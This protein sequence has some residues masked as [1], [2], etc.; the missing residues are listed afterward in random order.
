[1]LTTDLIGTSV[2]FDP[3]SMSTTNAFGRYRDMQLI[4]R[5][6][7]E[8]ANGGIRFVV[9]SVATGKLFDRDC[10]CFM[11]WDKSVLGT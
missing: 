10:D 11:L 3:E 6:V 8:G 2:K 1:M 4:V 9:A 7:Y 5:V